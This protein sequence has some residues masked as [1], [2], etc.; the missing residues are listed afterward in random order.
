VRVVSEPERALTF[1]R[2]GFGL[3]GRLAGAAGFLL[4]EKVFLNFFVDFESARTAE[5]LGAAV[6]V[7]QHWGF[8]FLTS[9]AVSTAVFAYL[10]G[11]RELREL[12]MAARALPPLR[13]RWLL[14]HLVLFAALVPL[15]ASLYGHA[16]W[17]PFGAVAA[18]WL[19]LALLAAAALVA[20]LAPRT[21]WQK[22]IRALGPVWGYAL[23]AAAGA[24]LAMGFS[25]GLWAAMARV[26]FEAVY[27]LLDALVPS[28]EIDPANLVIDSGRF[29]V[30]ID[31]VC[32]GLEGM[33]LMLA[34]GTVLL[35]LFRHEYIFPRALLLI[36]AGLLLSFALN[37]ARIA[38]LVLIGDAGYPEAAVYGFHSQAGWITFNAAAVGIAVVSLRSRWFSRAAAERTTAVTGENPTAVYLL[39]YL[40]VIL[41]V[42]LSRTVS[43][44][45]EGA[46]GLRLLLAGAALG[47]SLPRLHGVDWRFSWRG[48]LAGLGIFLVWI[49]AAH[50]ILPGQG[51]PQPLA[52]LSSVSRDLLVI[53]HILVSV[54]VIPLAEELAFRGYLMRRL[55][56]TDFESLSPRQA[57]TVALV[58]SAV[59]YG[60][61]QGTF[62]LPGVIAGAVFG[63]LYG[64]T[65]RL[66]EAVAAHVTGNALI[67]VAV[68]AGSRWQLW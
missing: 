55:Q 32:S 6:R 64:R 63:L 46:Y 7:A 9:F 60:L 35:L 21:L 53:G 39:P 48:G 45:F 34:F 36:P 50:F 59:V 30:S 15:S 65:G 66:G 38:G 47:Y 14:A 27:R 3:G 40:A 26:T 4:L 41:G 33:G 52:A 68:L 28:L 49:T 18:L 67:A 12:D 5:G 13:P 43:S 8:R 19:L 25:Q 17:L 51:I 62:W 20:A 54:G 42:M 44:G 31:P 61:C 1:L 23:V 56:T 16:T 22:A 37:I 24:A 11:G 57:G 2:P 10:R 29:A 58:A